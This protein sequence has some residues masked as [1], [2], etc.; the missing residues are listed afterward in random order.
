MKDAIREWYKLVMNM[1]DKVTTVYHRKNRLC[2]RFDNEEDAQAVAKLLGKKSQEFKHL[3]VFHFMQE[4]D[5]RMVPFT[6]GLALE[7]LAI[8]LGIG[9]SNILTIGNGH[10]DIS[11]LDG[12]VAKFMGCPENAE[13]D[14]MAVVSKSGGHVASRKFMGGVIDV[15]DAYLENHVSSELPEWW[16]AN[17]EKKNPRSVKRQMNH[18]PKPQKSDKRKIITIGTIVMIIYSVLLVFANFGIIPFSD[19]IRKP[20]LLA[21]ELVVKI[22]E[23][24]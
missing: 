20:V 23:S 1:T 24:I 17:K 13:T 7:E 8:R 10:N 18:P 15:I 11:M 22:L 5:V 12:V 21:M 6:K 4:V 16:V 19:I 9:A 14:V 2:L 3:R